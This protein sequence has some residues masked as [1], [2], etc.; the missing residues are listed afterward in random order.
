MIFKGSLCRGRYLL[1]SLIADNPSHRIATHSFS[2][3]LLAAPLLA[4]R[5]IAKRR[6]SAEVVSAFYA[7]LDTMI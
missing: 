6:C 1:L 4:V 5:V 2:F 7:L 3:R